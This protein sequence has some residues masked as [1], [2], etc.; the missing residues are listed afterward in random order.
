MIRCQPLIFAYQVR[1]EGECI[2]G[3]ENLWVGKKTFHHGLHG[4]N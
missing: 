4:F 3:N 2:E 1:D